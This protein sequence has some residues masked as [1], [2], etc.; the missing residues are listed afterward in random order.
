MIMKQKQA[1]A[2]PAMAAVLNPPKVGL[3][4]KLLVI[5]FLL[6]HVVF[7]VTLRSGKSV[8]VSD[9]KTHKAISPQT[10]AKNMPTKT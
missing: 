1:R 5:V 7:F 3:N 9:I 2:S 6:S 10:A 8:E 4:L